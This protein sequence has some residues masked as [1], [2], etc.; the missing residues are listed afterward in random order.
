M[1]N[2]NRHLEM[3]GDDDDDDVDDRHDDERWCIGYCN[4]FFIK[5]LN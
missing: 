4:D 3:K 5:P 2:E 1:E